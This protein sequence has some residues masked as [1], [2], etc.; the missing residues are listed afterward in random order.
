[1]DSQKNNTSFSRRRFLK[2]GVTAAGV[3]V[4]NAC[5]PVAPGA[6]QAPQVVE[7]VVTATPPA[8]A[9]PA[10]SN[11]V[12]KWYGWPFH[13]DFL[14]ASA[15]EFAQL[16]SDPGV[17][18]LS[19]PSG[20]FEPFV[21]SRFIAQQPV[22]IVYTQVPYINRWNRAGWIRTV[23]DLP[24]AQEL[25][26]ALYPTAREAFTNSE[27]QLAGLPYF[28][29][30][31]M[32]GYNKEHLDKAKLTPPNTWDELLDQ[33]R[34]L[35]T[36][37][38]AKFPILMWFWGELG[39]L[40]LQLFADCFSIGETV[41]TDKGDPTDGKGL[42][43]ILNYYQTIYKEGLTSP[44]TLS[45]PLAPIMAAGDAT[46]MTVEDYNFFRV[47][48]DTE[49]S[50]VTGKIGYNLYP[51]TTHEVYAG[52]VAYTM[53]TNTVDVARAWE[54]M[55]FLGGKAKDGK[56]HHPVKWVVDGGL[57]TAYPELMQSAQTRE[58]WGKWMDMD[59]HDKQAELARPRV[60]QKELWYAEWITL[61]MPAVQD[62]IT[63]KKTV[64]ETVTSL[65]DQAVKLKKAYS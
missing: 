42:T 52:G 53:G 55:K 14:D 61:M 43:Q 63:G 17:E 37:G 57:G 23:Q 22:D 49:F 6:L 2:L 13:K 9:A 19:A 50:K 60:G 5:A 36:D 4:V 27:G 54:L 32:F 44:D 62:A 31:Y 20:A 45:G 25:M 38:V 24:G 26:D 8:T 29:S 1:M 34:K 41:F 21:E 48:T 10:T 30:I 56:F 51:G 16:Y 12:M 39:A 65:Y 47:Q 7:K 33:A 64:D 28:W 3:A 40:D 11:A 59:V 46:F 18:F 58:V 35:K 15:Q